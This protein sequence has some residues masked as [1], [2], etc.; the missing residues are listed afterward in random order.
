MKR[1]FSQ[2]P[3]SLATQLPLWSEPAVARNPKGPGTLFPRNAGRGISRPRNND[4]MPAD[5]RT[6]VTLL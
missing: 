2:T 3:A 4:A 1:R 6:L 5:I